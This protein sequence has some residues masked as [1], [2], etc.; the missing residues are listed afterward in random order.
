MALPFLAAAQPLAL[1]L[2]RAWSAFEAD[3]QLRAGIASLYVAE[4]TTGKPVLERNAR[5]GLAPASTLKVITAATACEVLGPDYR[6]TTQ[7]AHD[8]V[9][10]QGRL[11]G[12]LYVIGSG[13][14]TLGSWRWNDRS[15]DSV[16]ARMV[17]AVRRKGIGN[18]PGSL[19]PLTPGW[20]DE[21]IPDGWIWADVGQYYGAGSTGISWHE[22]QFR[23]KLQPGVQ[24][25]DSIRLLGTEPDPLQPVSIHAKTG[26]AGSGDESYLYHA[27]GISEAS[28][29]RGPVLRGTL[30]PGKVIT[31]SGSLP[32]PELSFMN[33]L[34]ARLELQVQRGMPV[35]G[36]PAPTRD[37][38]RLTIFYSEQSPL[39]DSIN[40]W[41]LRKSINLYGEALLKTMALKQAG[42]ASTRAGAAIV[43]TFWK[44]RGVDPA[45]LRIVDG[46]GLSPENRVTTQAQVQV[47][48]YARRQSWVEGF[49]KGFPEYNGMRMKSGTIGGVKGYCGYHRSRDGKEYVFSILVNN[50]QGRESDIVRKIYR[51]LDELK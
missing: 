23:M 18:Y 19:V 30:P 31:V 21:T 33:D 6:F 41:F 17:R 5:M 25:G 37:T 16:L 43:R 7:L 11:R 24:E 20:G 29:R 35:P 13:D 49:V 12:H 51:V 32:D 40:Y 4:T 36:L 3:S 2:G 47:L 39:L 22:N 38:S 28:I 44:E 50:Y 42:T 26:R 27:L 34:K 45:A 14:P 15:A 10:E 46:S 48:L 9:I 8:G 1:R